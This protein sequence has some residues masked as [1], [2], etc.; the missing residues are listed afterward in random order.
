MLLMIYLLGY[1]ATVFFSMFWVMATDACSSETCNY[2]VLTYAYVAN[3]LV[4]GVV[5][6]AITVAAVILMIRKRIAFWLPLIGIGTQVGLLAVSVVLL[7]NI[8]Y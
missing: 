3:D 7:G 5:A 1:A 4:G 8:T 2:N 6:L